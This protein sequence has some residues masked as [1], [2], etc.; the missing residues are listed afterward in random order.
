MKPEIIFEN[1]FF[2]AVH[3][4]SGLLS[5]ADRMGKEQSLKDI[6]IEKY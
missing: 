1:E 4:P 5:I 6:L 2:V 3:K